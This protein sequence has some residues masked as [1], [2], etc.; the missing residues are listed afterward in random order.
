MHSQDL[1]E[2]MIPTE[3]KTSFLQSK[4]VLQISNWLEPVAP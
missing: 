4:Q 3:F 2:A 1:A